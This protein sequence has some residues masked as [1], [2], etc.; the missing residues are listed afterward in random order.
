MLLYLLK[1]PALEI[2]RQRFLFFK[3]SDIVTSGCIYLIFGVS[4]LFHVK[5]KLACSN[6]HMLIRHTS[7]RSSKCVLT[8]VFNLDPYWAP[9]LVCICSL[10]NIYTEY[11]E[12]RST[13]HQGPSEHGLSNTVCWYTLFWAN[14][15]TSAHINILNLVQTFFLYNHIAVSFSLEHICGR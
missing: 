12:T 7:E 4:W 5:L 15:G 9:F 1:M 10:L 13:A 14:I 11:I 8:I 3:M 2:G 6:V